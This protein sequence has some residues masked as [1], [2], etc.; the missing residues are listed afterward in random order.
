MINDID[1]TQSILM[2]GVVIYF[3]VRDA[4]EKLT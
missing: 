2:I 4:H 3:L 1:I